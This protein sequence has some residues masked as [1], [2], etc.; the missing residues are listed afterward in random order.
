[1]TAGSA[2][3]SFRD[4]A[5]AWRQGPAGREP[6]PRALG[7]AL[8]PFLALWTLP[9]TL[10]GLVYALGKRL[11]GERVGLYRFGPFVFLVVP[12]RPLASSGISL[13]LVVFADRP[14]ILTHEFCHLYTGLW[15]SWLYLPV[16]GL[17]Y[18]VLGHGRSFHERI[19]VWLEQR[20]RYGWRPW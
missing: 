9:Q 20:T 7:L 12:D 6:W 1:M 8:V 15:L 5:S 19:T 17:E 10:A 13:G 4:A 14:S 2:R 18:L 11:R 3:D 16:Y